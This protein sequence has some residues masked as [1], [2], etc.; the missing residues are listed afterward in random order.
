MKKINSIKQLQAEKKKMAQHQQALEE[1]I[2]NNWTDLRGSM[3]PANL[4]RNAFS[5]ILSKKTD[6]FNNKTILKG[7]LTVGA[8]LLIKRMIRKKL[9]SM[10][11]RK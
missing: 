11:R 3:K 6:G 8:T 7:L 5:Q 10:F 2:G 4:A 1:K 9:G